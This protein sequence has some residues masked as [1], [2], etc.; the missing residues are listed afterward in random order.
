MI[1]LI[2]QLQDPDILPDLRHLNEGRPQK[3][4][5]FGEYCK[6]F[7]EECSAVDERRHGETTHLACAISV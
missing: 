7:I 2:I 6:K 4:Q 5:I 3:Y 1:Q